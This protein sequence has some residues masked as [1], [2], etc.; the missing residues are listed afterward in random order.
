M[1]GTVKYINEPTT[2][3]TCYV[4][5]ICYLIPHNSLMR[6]REE[7]PTARGTQTRGVRARIRTR[8][9]GHRSL[10]RMRGSAPAALAAGAP[11]R[12]GRAG[13]AW[14]GPGGDAL[15]THRRRGRAAWPFIAAARALRSRPRHDGAGREHLARRHGAARGSPGRPWR[16]LARPSGLRLGLAPCVPPPGRSPPP[17]ARPS[18]RSLSLLRPPGSS[19]ASLSSRR[20]LQAPGRGS[21][22]GAP[23]TPSPHP[24]LAHTGCSPRPRASGPQFPIKGEDAS[25]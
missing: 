2:P 16:G 13:R 22:D 7:K 20:S 10:L 18:R 3:G 17:A 11:W 8:H 14:Q 9:A 23:A 4:H 24:G 6:H 1:G 12:P 25:L 5:W 19:P 21:R 15:L